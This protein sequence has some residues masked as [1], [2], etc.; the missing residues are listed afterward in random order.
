[1]MNLVD[2]YV[3]DNDVGLLSSQ[4]DSSAVGTT[5]EAARRAIL[6]CQL[7]GYQLPADKYDQWQEAVITFDPSGMRLR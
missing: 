7:G 4:G 5:F 6:R 1:M 2:V 3:R